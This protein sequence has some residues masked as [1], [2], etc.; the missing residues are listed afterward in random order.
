MQHLWMENFTWK[1]KYRDGITLKKTV[2]NIAN[3]ISSIEKQVGINTESNEKTGNTK[4]SLMF[5]PNL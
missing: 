2:L 3:K 5:L 4:V 1:D